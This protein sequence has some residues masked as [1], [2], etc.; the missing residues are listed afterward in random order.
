MRARPGLPHEQ[1]VARE[2]SRELVGP[3]HRARGRAVREG[4]HPSTGAVSDPPERGLML[5][6][7]TAIALVLSFPLGGGRLSGLA[8]I[9]IRAVWAVL[10]AAAIQVGISD[11]APGGS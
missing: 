1:A 3:A 2:E 8:D 6:V 11:V 5:L 7:V 4:G 9:R 10:L